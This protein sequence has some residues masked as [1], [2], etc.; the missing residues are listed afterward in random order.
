MTIEQLRGQY[1]EIFGE[2]GL[3]TDDVVPRRAPEPAL[4]L[5]FT[6]RSGS[7]YL[8]ELL[9]STQLLGRAHEAF[10]PPFV[11]RHLERWD[12]NE[13]TLVSYARNLR[14][15]ITR[16]G[17]SPPIFK[18]GWHQLFVLAETGVLDTVFPNRKLV[19]IQ[20]Q[21]L[22][23]QAVSFTIASR[24]G[25]WTSSHTH[26]DSELDID[27]SEVLTRIR[28]VLVATR[29][30]RE[31]AAVTG[32]DVLDVTYEHVEDDPQRVVDRIFDFAGLPR[33]PID[34]SVVRVARQRSTNNAEIAD[35][36]VADAHARLD[37]PVRPAVSAD[38]FPVRYTS[39]HVA[40]RLT[41]IWG[42]GM[43]AEA[44][45][46]SP[47]AEPIVDNLVLVVHSVFAD[48]SR[49]GAWL[50]SN[51][52]IDNRVERLFPVD[53][54]TA[55]PD[56]LSRH[57]EQAVEVDPGARYR[58]SLVR[59]FELCWLL[60]TRIVPR[61][62]AIPRVLFVRRVDL[63]SAGA[64]MFAEWHVPSPVDPVDATREHIRAVAGSEAEGTAAA[65]VFGL[66]SAELVIGDPTV[67]V[68]DRRDRVAQLLDLEPGEL[69][70]PDQSLF[71]HSAAD[72][73]ERSARDGVE[74]VWP[75]GVEISER[76]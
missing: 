64:D 6:N 73:T 76:R 1:L 21:D 54:A 62:I 50:A 28:S 63:E 48:A 22:L 5:C 17:G 43:L 24:T 37:G 18:I 36:V 34:R 38:T 27:P 13:R 56:G 46:R 7:N 68:V 52:V 55:H 60:D 57:L 26:Q 30:F 10:N 39:S 74:A 8:A 47:D 58:L 2:Q 59:P 51:D 29:H 23:A 15:R 71:A 25:A 53:S 40:D 61:L 31:F 14:P 69:D 49:A 45:G 16:Q 20:R 41:A 42:P 66:R 3:P 72:R 70:V 35:R 19:V 9:R 65:A 4:L 44:S 67:D 12:L 75:L 32:D 11:A 33:T